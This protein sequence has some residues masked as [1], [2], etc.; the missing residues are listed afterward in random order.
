MHVLACSMHACRP[1]QIMTS[2]S[3]K[4]KSDYDQYVKNHLR[5]ERNLGRDLGEPLRKLQSGIP[6]LD[7]IQNDPGRETSLREDSVIG[8]HTIAEWPIHASKSAFTEAHPSTVQTHV[9]SSIIIS[10]TQYFSPRQ[11][12]HLC[13]VGAQWETLL[14]LSSSFEE[15]GREVA[16][17]RSFSLRAGLEFKLTKSASSAY[18]LRLPHNFQIT[19]K[20]HSQLS[21]FK[22]ALGKTQVTSTKQVLWR[23]SAYLAQ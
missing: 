19:I 5:R 4:I 11:V 6:C 22:S 7:H 2:Y 23:G 15:W 3:I 16:F 18:H 8:T 20:T 14:P 1:K 10:D 9:L 12:H 13:L 17:P 21:T